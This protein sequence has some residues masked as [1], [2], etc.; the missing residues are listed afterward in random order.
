MTCYKY[1][2]CALMV[3]DEASG[4]QP[5]AEFSTES[6]SENDLIPLFQALKVR[7]PS[8]EPKYFMS[9]CASSFWNA[10]Q[11]VFGGTDKRTK[12]ITCAWHIWRA[13][14]GQ[15]QNGAYKIGTTEL[16]RVVRKCLATLMYEG[17]E[18]EFKRNYENIVNNLWI[19]GE[20]NVK[21]FHEYFLR[22]YPA[23]TAHDWTRF[24]RLYSDIT[25]NMHLEPYHRVLKQRFLNRK[26]SQSP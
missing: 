20:E 9:D 19:T 21:K 11:K 24:G 5:V 13:L 8:L 25:T 4:G 22:Y 18:A 12:R 14:N 23:S 15:M 10:W 26:L 17:D 6:E 2:L 7:R 1:L 3:L 16:R